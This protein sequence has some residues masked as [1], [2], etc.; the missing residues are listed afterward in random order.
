MN[1]QRMVIY[2]PKSRTW[3]PAALRSNDQRQVW[4]R[5]KD[6]NS[7]PMGI[8]YRSTRRREPAWPRATIGETT[9]RDWEFPQPRLVM[10]GGRSGV[11]QGADGWW[12]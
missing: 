10:Q 5:D 12:Y 9:A 7:G 4:C 1:P 11:V 8:L 6:N 2:M 3:A